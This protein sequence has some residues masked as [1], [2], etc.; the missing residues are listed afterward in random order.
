MLD[1]VTHRADRLIYRLVE[2]NPEEL[3]EEGI[4]QQGS[5]SYWESQLDEKVLVGSVKTANDYLQFKR[6]RYFDIQA[7]RLKGA[8]QKAT[9]LA[10]YVTQEAASQTE[11]ENGIQFYGEIIDVEIMDQSGFII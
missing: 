5:I 6:G 1:A 3:Q 7:D 2:S 10:L 9:Y 11:A 8:W 4:L